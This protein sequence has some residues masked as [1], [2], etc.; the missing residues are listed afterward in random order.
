MQRNLFKHHG[1]PPDVNL[2]AVRWYCR[3][4][5]SCRDLRELLTERGI[6]TFNVRSMT[7]RANRKGVEL[8]LVT[9]HGLE[10]RLGYFTKGEF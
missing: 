8:R 9:R 10:D 5:L 6:K 3:F 2:C 7:K 1:F 4:A